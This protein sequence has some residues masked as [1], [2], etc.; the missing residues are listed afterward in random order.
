VRSRLLSF[1]AGVWLVGLFA[2]V[3]RVGATWRWYKDLPLGLD[4]NNYYHLQG[5]LFAEHKTI[6]DPFIWIDYGLVTPGAGHP[7]LYPTFL[8]VVSL[9]GFESPTAHR[10]AS[11]VMG[12]LG[13]VLVG[14]L[15]RRLGGNRVGLIAAVVAAVYPNLWINDGLILSE[16]LVTATVALV[17]IATYRWRDDPTVAKAAVLGGAIALA[18]L[19][20]S[21]MLSL[22]F[23]MVLPLFLLTRSLS[24]KRQVQMGLVCGAVVA[25][26]VAPWIIRNTLEFK[27]PATMATGSGRVLA[28]ANCDATYS[29]EFLGYWN[30]ACTLTEFPGDR[31]LRAARDELAVDPGD[32]A[33]QAAWQEAVQQYV[34]TVDESV[35]DTA[36]REKA[37]AYIED[38][39]TEL[40][41]VVA[42]RIGRMWDVY[43]PGQGIDFNVFFERRGLWPSRAALGMYYV[44]LPL[45][46]WGLVIMRRRKQTIIPFLGIAAM[47]TFTA[48]STFGITRY[49]VPLE[50]GIVVL[51]AISVDHVWTRFRGGGASD[52]AAEDDEADD[53]GEAAGGDERPAPEPVPA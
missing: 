8:G 42:A 46:V 19:N 9:A 37:S 49:R 26:V 21:E 11:C 30:D 16:S 51:A 44:L 2:L 5:Q 38:H 35:I 52:A 23:F 7:P 13:V 22:C 24:F 17:L 12:A 41:P 32:P 25:A 18:G 39:W 34:A 50:V 28:Y 29:G 48:A 10:L 43:R 3:V 27:D 40:P 4:D 47:I 1:R 53:G 45:A 31:E 6:V 15:G 14:Y 20:R 36:H 33:R